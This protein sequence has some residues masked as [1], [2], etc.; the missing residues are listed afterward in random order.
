M[1]GLLAKETRDL[2]PVALVGAAAAGA[3][4]WA[5]GAEQI[6]PLPGLALLCAASGAAVGVAQGLLDRRRRDDPFLLHRPVS[7]VRIHAERGA[8]GLALAAAL[9]LVAVLAARAAPW[10]RSQTV[11]S[12]GG[13]TPSST[14]LVER[15]D[16]DLA[17]SLVCVACALVLHSL[18][19]LALTPRRALAAA[20]LLVVLPATATYA[21][22]SV[23]TAAA[24]WPL[25]A[26]F[27]GVAFTLATLQLS[28]RSA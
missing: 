18:A 27:V 23:E 14:G 2:A 21:L 13:G 10:T 8:A 25:L 16:P 26:V 20:T 22:L 7:A 11:W 12:A 1:S 19:R 15:T 6:F 9:A 4:G 24:P 5:I 17:A 28:A 3:A